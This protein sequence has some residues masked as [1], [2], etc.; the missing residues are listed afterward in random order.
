MS[1]LTATDDKKK[2]F[3]ALF[4][5]HDHTNG[6]EAVDRVFHE[7]KLALNELVIPTTRHEA[8]KYTRLGR[9]INKAWKVT[10][11]EEEIDVSNWRV[12]N[13]DSDCLV[14]VDG[15]FRSDLSEVQ[16][17]AGITVSS[18]GAACESVAFLAHFGTLADHK[19]QLFVALNGAHATGGG[20]IHFSRNTQRE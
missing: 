9:V 15:H 5:G 4:E 11:S 6:T 17:E 3:L 2:A 7:S 10:P 20:F 16:D 13:T 18:M 14:F 12:K 1:T 19:N 8:W